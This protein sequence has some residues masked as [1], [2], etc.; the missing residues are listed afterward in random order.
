M[1]STNTKVPSSAPQ[2]GVDFGGEGQTFVV[3]IGADGLLK[4]IH[5]DDLNGLLDEGEAAI[6]RASH[7]EPDGR[8]WFA[9]LAP[10]LG[11]KL[12]PFSTRRA[13]LRAEHDWLLENHLGV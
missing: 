2:I 10:V 1:N 8:D 4:F 3:V 5:D 12:G 11:P 13:A 9:D 7:V 6:T